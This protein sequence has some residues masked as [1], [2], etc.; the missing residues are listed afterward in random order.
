MIEIAASV[1]DR[2][3]RAG[4]HFEQIRVTLQPSHDE[5]GVAGEIARLRTNV[6]Q[7][8]VRRTPVEVDR[9]SAELRHA[10]LERD[11]GAGGRLLEDHHQRPA[12]HVALKLPAL[13]LHPPR[14]REQLANFAVI[15]ELPVDEV[16]RRPG[17]ACSSL[18]HGLVAS[19][20]SERCAPCGDWD[21]AP[22]RAKSASVHRQFQTPSSAGRWIGSGFADGRRR[23]SGRSCRAAGNH[24]AGRTTSEQ[25]APAA[26][27]SAPCPLRFAAARRPGT[28]A[29]GPCS[30][31]GRA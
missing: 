16:L 12:L 2:H 20:S 27:S 23:G 18:N 29:W 1:D 21:C 11:T 4:G 17:H 13:P 8:E 14:E 5:C 30:R 26:R 19:P 15:P 7:G 6:A 31:P 22:L 24:A 9:V 10:R 3:R 25:A 28:P